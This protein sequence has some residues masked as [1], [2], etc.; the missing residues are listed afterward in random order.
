[1]EVEAKAVCD[2]LGAIKSRIRDLGARFL[3]KGTQKDMYFNHPA[4]D[5]ARTD[6]ALRI[7]E[8][9]EKAYL[10]YKGP[11]MDELTKTRE[12]IAISVDKPENLLEI[13]KKLGF[14]EVRTVTKNR[15]K[16]QLD[17]LTVCLDSVEGLGDFVELEATCDPNDSERIDELRNRILNTLKE[18]N[19]TKIVRK[20][21]LELLL[22]K[23]T[24]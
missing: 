13:L 21:Y 4:R 9:G 8:V 22:E 6:E 2:D 16:Y 18:W 12:E 10:T 20:S 23:G 15:E 14:R 3:W 11:K 7:R 24:N 19:L 5:F 17:E 1:M